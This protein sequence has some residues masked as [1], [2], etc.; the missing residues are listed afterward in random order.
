M[1]SC[2]MFCWHDDGIM[3]HPV[4]V[5]VVM[6]W[7]A[8]VCMEPLILM[9]PMLSQVTMSCGRLSYCVMNLNKGRLS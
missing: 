9:R 3:G 2:V 7:N 8:N 6:T 4:M 1:L 5:H